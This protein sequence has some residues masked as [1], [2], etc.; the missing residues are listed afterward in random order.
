MACF[1][2]RSEKVKALTCEINIQFPATANLTKSALASPKLLVCLDCG[3][4]DVLLSEDELRNLRETSSS[5]SRETLADSAFTLNNRRQVPTMACSSCHSA[6]RREFPSEVSIHLPAALNEP[7]VLVLS[8]LSVCMK[9]GLTEF[10]I[11]SLE[12]KTLRD[13]AESWQAKKKFILK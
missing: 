6:N 2:C 7:T 8:Q 9:C 13:T 4:A 11:P 12:L 10:I 5:M 1:S 3:L